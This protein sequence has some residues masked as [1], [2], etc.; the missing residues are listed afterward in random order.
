MV[1]GGRE[2]Q[3]GE[4]VADG[5][6]WFH[7]PIRKSLFSVPKE[8]RWLMALRQ[9]FHDG[10]NCEYYQAYPIRYPRRVLYVGTPPVDFHAHND[11]H[12]HVRKR[13]EVTVALARDNVRCDAHH[14]VETRSFVDGQGRAAFLLLWCRLLRRLPYFIHHSNGLPQVLEGVIGTNSA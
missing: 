1:T 6:M 3:V 4:W 9:K 8:L 5:R 2:G 14:L 13:Y 7:T 12:A 10:V 11:G